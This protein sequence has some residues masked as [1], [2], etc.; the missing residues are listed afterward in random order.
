MYD[1]F[2]FFHCQFVK[3]YMCLELEKQIFLCPNSNV[4]LGQLSGT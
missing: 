1:H 3:Y 4:L 2:V